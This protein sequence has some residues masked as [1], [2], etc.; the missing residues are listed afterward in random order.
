MLGIVRGHRGGIQ[1][2]SEKGKGTTFRVMLPCSDQH[3]ELEPEAA[4]VVVEAKPEAPTKKTGTVLVVE[5]EEGVRKI[6]KMMLE[7]SGFGVLTANDGRAGL[8][9]FRQRM[10]E[11]D[12]V[13]LDLSMPYMSGKEVFREM[14]KLDPGVRVILSSGYTEEH[15]KMQFEGV[16]PAGFIQKPYLSSNLIEKVRSNLRV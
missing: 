3:V 11:I 2:W 14:I 1:V 7:R 4:E 15:V 6:T 8:D 13:V 16:K 9:L 12:I 10:K 5:D